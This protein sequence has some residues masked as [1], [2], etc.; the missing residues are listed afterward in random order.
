MPTTRTVAF[1]DLLRRHRRAT[2]LTQAELAERAGL[3]VQAVSALER[4]VNRA[5]HRDTVRLLAQALR[6]SD[7]E[8]ALLEGAARPL[9]SGTE[10]ATTAPPTDLFD[11]PSGLPLQL[12]SLVGR[13]Q[14]EAAAA[15]LLRQ[16][17]V[18]LLTLTGAPGIGKTRLAIQVAM[19]LRDSFA[20][21]ACFVDLAPVRDMAFVLPAIAHALDLRDTSGQP[22]AV[23]LRDMLRARQTLLVLDNFEQVTAAAPDVAGLLAACPHVKALVTSRATL[24]VRGEHELTVPPLALPAAAPLPAL[25]DLAQYAAVALF[26]QRARAVQ[27]T[28]ELTPANAATVVE[29]CQ[30]LDGLPLAIELAAAWIKVLPP[31]ALRSRLEHQLALLTGGAQDLPERQR[32]MQAA[33]AWSYDLLDGAQQRLFRRLA[34]F[35]GGW[36]LEAAEGVC[37]PATELGVDTL[38][39]L[40]ALVDQSLV[41]ERTEAGGAGRFTLLE[42]LREYGLERLEA[43]GE[44]TELGRRHADYF[45]ALAE[46]AEPRLI[47]PEQDVWLER[48]EADHDNM[49]AVLD[50]TLEQRDAELGLRLAGAVHR[51]WDRR[52]HLSEG[53][54]WTDRLLELD[55]ALPI[56]AAPAVRAKALNGA[57]VL[58]SRQG[59]YERAIALHEE[60]LALWRSLGDRRRE[61][62]ALNNLGTEAQEQ[63]DYVRAIAFYEESV[64]IKRDLGEPRTTAVSLGNLGDVLRD[65]GAFARAEALFVES[66]ALYEQAGDRW[67]VAVAMTNLGDILRRRGDLAGAAQLH[68]ESR[69]LFQAS[70]DHWG[71]AVALKNMADVACDRGELAEARALYGESL[72]L[73][74][75]IG[76]QLGTVWCLEGAACVAALSDEPARAAQLYGAAEALRRSIRTPLPPADRAAY[77]RDVAA[78]REVLGPERFAAAWAQGQAAPQHQVAALETVETVERRT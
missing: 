47:G 37:G 53:R 62:M 78:L 17:E 59:D 24:H 56:P 74:R 14:D 54:L 9:A 39:G 8:R 40:R 58:A 70:Q 10:L 27:P 12:E 5:P 3:S 60:T 26:V 61:A 22:L 30:R 65:V 75:A 36:T 42:T 41:R 7:A 31:V 49:R 64:A 76:N 16:P 15:H 69:A 28:F 21:G 46:T 43:S 52:G 19:S 72:G 4:G 73:Y 67:G 20:D 13:E 34:V 48:L 45:V 38:L 50:W 77:E 29:I 68:M 6:L 2:G 55:R 18:R 23:T 25:S 71:V 57:G 51:F 11:V 35:V 66:R 33:I 63:G 32:T 1:A 44:H